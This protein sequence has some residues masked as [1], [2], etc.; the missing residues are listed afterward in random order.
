ML[1]TADGLLFPCEGADGGHKGLE[2]DPELKCYILAMVDRYL[3][4]D[5]FGSICR[6]LDVRDVSSKGAGC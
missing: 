1:L 2:P 5:S 3:S 6:W 4:G